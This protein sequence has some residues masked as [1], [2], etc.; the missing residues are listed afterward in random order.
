MARIHRAIEDYIK[1]QESNIDYYKTK[2]K[3]TD[4]AEAIKEALDCLLINLSDCDIEYDN[5]EK[6][7][8]KYVSKNELKYYTE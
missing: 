3:N 4:K 7:L 2:E 8:Y 5:E 1:V 6:R